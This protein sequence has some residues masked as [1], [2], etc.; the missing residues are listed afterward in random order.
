MPTD[1]KLHSAIEIR[2]MKCKQYKEIK[3]QKTIFIDS[4]TPLANLL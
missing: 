4:K 2:C 1:C 3:K